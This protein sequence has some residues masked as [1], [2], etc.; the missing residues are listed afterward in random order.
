MYSFTITSTNPRAYHP[1]P[2]STL[3][4]LVNWRTWG[5]VCPEAFAW[6]VGMQATPAESPRSCSV[7]STPRAKPLRSQSLNERSRNYFETAL[8]GEAQSISMDDSSTNWPYTF[9]N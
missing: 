4:G 1:I 8:G 6:M 9:V 7:P 2:W 3:H 5:A